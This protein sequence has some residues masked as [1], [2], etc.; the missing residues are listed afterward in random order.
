MNLMSLTFEI[1]N[2]KFKKRNLKRLFN[3]QINASI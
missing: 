1:R 2:R 3:A